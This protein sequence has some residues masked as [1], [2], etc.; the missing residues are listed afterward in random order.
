MLENV[1]AMLASVVHFAPV[2][3]IRQANELGTEQVQG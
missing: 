2:S 1:L 3:V